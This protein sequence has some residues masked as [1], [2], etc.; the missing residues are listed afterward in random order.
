LR[1]AVFLHT[2]PP[3]TNLDSMSTGCHH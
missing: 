2:A 1:A 3:T